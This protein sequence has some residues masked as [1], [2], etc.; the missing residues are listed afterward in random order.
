MQDRGTG[1]VARPTRIPG[2]DEGP[3]AAA[4]RRAACAQFAAG[5]RSHHCRVPP[6]VVV[7]EQQWQFQTVAGA[8]GVVRV[9]GVHPIAVD[10]GAV[11]GQQIREFGGAVLEGLTAD[12]LLQPGAEARA[13]PRH[14]AYPGEHRMGT[15]VERAHL[16]GRRADD[17]L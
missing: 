8:E 4:R 7:A 2:A 10:V 9:Q 15:T 16:V 5:Q 12:Q 6:G 1:Q 3:P 14:T 11:G 17:R 13:E